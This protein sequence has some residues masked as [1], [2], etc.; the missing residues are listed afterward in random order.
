MQG[1]ESVWDGCRIKTLLSHSIYTD[2]V[3][4]F[5]VADNELWHLSPDQ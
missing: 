5:R 4:L 2:R 3:T 1:V